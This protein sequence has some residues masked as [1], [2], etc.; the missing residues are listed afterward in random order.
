MPIGRR[1]IGD[2]VGGSGDDHSM[3]TSRPLR[4]RSGL[5]QRARG[6]SRRLVADG[7][8]RGDAGGER[9]RRGPARGSVRGN[10][11]TSDHRTRQ[12][13]D[14]R[15][16]ARYGVDESPAQF[17]QEKAKN[18]AGSPASPSG[19][20]ASCRVRCM[21]LPSCARRDRAGRAREGDHQSI[22]DLSASLRGPSG[23]GL[24]NLAATW[25]RARR[26]VGAACMGGSCPAI[27]DWLSS[28]RR[29]G[30]GLPAAVALLRGSSSRCCA[31]ASRWPT[32][33]PNVGCPGSTGW[34]CSS[35]RRPSSS[36]TSLPR[37][38]HATA[39]PPAPSLS[40]AGRSDDRFR[41]GAVIG[42]PRRG[43][44]PLPCR[45]RAAPV[46][47]CSPTDSSSERPALRHRHR[48]DRRNALG[49]AERAH[50]D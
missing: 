41:Q 49:L 38:T 25:R 40:R 42:L 1:R 6:P 43:A 34:T 22:V 33:S 44:S 7:S 14:K 15:Y 3:T 46:W 47:S 5:A 30:C 45:F 8:N 13:A 18:I 37:L 16:R 32:A 20:T 27:T 10:P 39:V 23:G 9:P 11:A 48:P 2:V 35:L 31:P 12:G 28:R 24:R 19:S 50:P 17:A 36:R 26:R 4:S 29:T 21:L